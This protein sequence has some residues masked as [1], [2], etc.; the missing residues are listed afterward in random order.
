MRKVI[1][2]PNS[3]RQDV[4]SPTQAQQ[5]QQPML[6]LKLQP[7]HQ[8]Q[9]QPQPNQPQSAT[10]PRKVLNVRPSPH[11]AHDTQQPTPQRPQ[12]VQQQPGLQS[13]QQPLRPM[14][15]NPSTSSQFPQLQQATQMMRGGPAYQNQPRSQ[16]SPLSRSTGDLQRPSMI[17]HNQG[18]MGAHERPSYNQN[19]PLNSNASGASQENASHAAVK[20]SH[21]QS[22]LGASPFSDKHVSKRASVIINGSLAFVTPSEAER[23]RTISKNRPDEASK[24]AAPVTQP[25]APVIAKPVVPVTTGTAVVIPDMIDFTFT[26]PVKIET[27]KWTNDRPAPRDTRKSF[28]FQNMEELLFEQQRQIDEEQRKLDSLER[29]VNIEEEELLKRQRELELEEEEREKAQKD[30]ELQQQRELELLQ[31]QQQ[32]ELDQL[33]NQMRLEREQLERGREELERLQYMEFEKMQKQ[34]LEELDRLKREQE[35][36][37]RAQEEA[38]RMLEEARKE[39]VARNVPETPVPVVSKVE[40]VQPSPQQQTTSTASPAPNK[41]ERPTKLTLKNEKEKLE[42]LME[43]AEGENMVKAAPKKV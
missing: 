15:Q 7:I 28:F 42:I 10:S 43:I 38:E 34:Q 2:Q 29:R 31:Q 35:A 18:I 16:P 17:Q 22:L 40:A 9:Q 39:E 1:E 24:L 19:Q 14:G 11:S 36:A 30:L 4:Q 12:P 26:N 6:P 41:V 25:V 33:N 5:S 23:I 3:P 32:E 20:P 37:E 8:Q 21:R 27:E 13:Q